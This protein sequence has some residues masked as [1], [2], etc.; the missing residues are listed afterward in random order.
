M[1]V[2]GLLSDQDSIQHSGLIHTHVHR[3]RERERE[4]MGHHCPHD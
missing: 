1:E 4:S 3:E 2:K